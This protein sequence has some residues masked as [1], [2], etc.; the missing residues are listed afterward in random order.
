MVRNPVHHRRTKHIDIRYHF[1][2]DHFKA[3]RISVQHMP[4]ALLPADAFTKALDKIKF[5]EHR[6]QMMVKAQS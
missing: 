6:D 3:G 2:R 1:I 4:T 5:L